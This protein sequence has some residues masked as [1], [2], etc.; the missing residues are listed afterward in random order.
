ME[1]SGQLNVSAA[2][3]LWSEPPIN[4]EYEDAWVPVSVYVFCRRGKSL[5]VVKE[6]NILK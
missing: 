2:L 3:P 5:A 6:K 4:F 1:A